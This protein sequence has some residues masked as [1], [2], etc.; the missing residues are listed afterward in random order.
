[1]AKASTRWQRRHDQENE[2]LQE[3]EALKREEH[4][5]KKFADVVLEV[6]H[7]V[8]YAHVQ[9]HLHQQVASF[10]GGLC[11]SSSRMSSVL[12][13]D[14]SAMCHA[15]R[16]GVTV[17][18]PHTACCSVSVSMLHACKMPAYCI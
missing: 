11:S 10:Q 3:K 17:A 9:H 15:S 5:I 7:E 13:R 8:Q 4:E 6:G 12:C 18:L 2:A 1:M 14:E 16:P